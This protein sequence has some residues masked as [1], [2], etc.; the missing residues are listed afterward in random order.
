MGVCLHG[1]IQNCTVGVRNFRLCVVGTVH[2]LYEALRDLPVCV[3]S[4]WCLYG[5]VCQTVVQ[6]HTTSVRQCR[7]CQSAS[8]GAVCCHA[9]FLNRTPGVQGNTGPPSF[10]T[11]LVERPPPRSRI[12]P[13]SGCSKIPFV[14]DYTPWP[15]ELAC[16]LLELYTYCTRCYRTSHVVY[17]ACGACTASNVGVLYRTVQWVYENSVCTRVD[18]M[19]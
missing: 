17:I 4:L 13:Y 19:A 14:P 9:H 12:E 16:V 7:L 10:S 5:V 11:A 6:I 3:Y 2:L 18:P 1:V 15:G 8:L